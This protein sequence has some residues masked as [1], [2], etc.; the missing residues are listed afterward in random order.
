VSLLDGWENEHHLSRYGVTSRGRLW[1]S[2]EVTTNIFAAM[3]SVSG[4]YNC[5]VDVPPGVPPSDFLA[6]AANP[7]TTGQGRIALGVSE[8]KRLRVQVLDVA[9]RRVRTLAD[10]WFEQGEHTLVW[11]GADDG[12]RVL[13]RGVYFVHVRGLDGGVE[14]TQ[15]VV[16]LR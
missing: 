13:A 12:G 16:F 8:R 2:C 14:D 10:R 4:H 7:V 1:Y 11:D 5:L 6:L 3:C 15:K 9:G